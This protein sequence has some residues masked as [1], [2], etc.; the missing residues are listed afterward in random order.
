MEPEHTVRIELD[1]SRHCVATETRA[2]Y[3]RLVRDFFK[4][5]H[6]EQA[7]A[8]ERIEALRHVLESGD[9]GELRT[10]NAVLDGRGGEGAGA[11]LVVEPGG[12]YWVEQGGRAH[13]PLL[14]EG[15]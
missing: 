6:E 5:N 13:E 11:V 3:E 12:R 9:L 1:L 8:G 14:T 15:G 2:V 10:R 7:A 4:M